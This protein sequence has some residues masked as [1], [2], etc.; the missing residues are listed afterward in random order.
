MRSEIGKRQLDDIFS[1]RDILNAGIV[2]NM[3]VSAEP[4]GIE[5]LRYEIRDIIP[6][7]AVR[8]SMELQAEAERR[9][10]AHI[11]ESEGVRQSE[12]NRAEGEKQSVVLASEAALIEKVNSAKGTAEAI[13]RQARATA[14]GLKFVGAAVSGE[15]GGAEAASLRVAEQYVDAFRELAKEGNTILLP[16]QTNNASAMVAEAMT[17][18]SNLGKGP[19]AQGTKKVSTTTIDDIVNEGKR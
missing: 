12:I 3:R 2:D 7:D 16:A 13:E 8:E 18:Y 6:P 10:R 15:Q 9:K 4:W 19:T 17:I 11:L 14:N 1:E 5:V